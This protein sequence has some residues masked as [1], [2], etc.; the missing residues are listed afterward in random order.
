MYSKT[1][2]VLVKGKSSSA[3]DPLSDP[4]YLLELQ[5]TASESVHQ[6]SAFLRASGPAC[7]VPTSMVPT[8]KGHLSHQK[9]QGRILGVGIL[10]V[11]ESHFEHNAGKPSLTCVNLVVHDN[12]I[13]DILAVVADLARSF[14]KSILVGREDAN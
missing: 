9:N 10:R 13:P 4:L 1:L 12:R 5:M 6:R 8:S 2:T 7:M 11:G 3:A 14:A